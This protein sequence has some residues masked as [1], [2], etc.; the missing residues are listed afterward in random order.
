MVNV[1]DDDAALLWDMLQAC[2]AVKRFVEKRSFDAYLND[3]LLRSAVERQIEII[4]EAASKVSV[5]TRAANVDIPWRKI[6]A[7]RNALAHEYGELKHELLWQVVT[8]HIPRL[9]ERLER[10]TPN[11]PDDPVNS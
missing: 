2:R 7:Q 9:I 10:I 3:L 5:A 8:E 6:I 4:G 11:P 1:D